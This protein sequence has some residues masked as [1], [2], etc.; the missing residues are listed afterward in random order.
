M[1]DT[2]SGEL[3]LVDV[4]DIALPSLLLLYPSSTISQSRSLSV[5]MFAMDVG[6]GAVVVSRCLSVAAKIT[7]MA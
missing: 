4:A 6:A 2:G 1:R 7:M 5:I 3:P